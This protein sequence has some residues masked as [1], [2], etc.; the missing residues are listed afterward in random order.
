MR[1]WGVL[2]LDQDALTHYRAERTGIGLAPYRTGDRSGSRRRSTK[3]EAPLPVSKVATGFPYLVGLFCL[4]SWG[5]GSGVWW[6]SV[7]GR[8]MVEVIRQG[9]EWNGVRTFGP[10]APG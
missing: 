3:D 10:L 8:S 1:E 5:A 6:I 9:K 7:A 2:N 4:R